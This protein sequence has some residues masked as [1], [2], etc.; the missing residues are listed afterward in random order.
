MSLFS[1]L[2]GKNT[3]EQKQA[4]LP[5]NKQEAL[6]KQEADT[7]QQ[8]QSLKTIQQDMKSNP[9][10]SLIQTAQIEAQRLEKESKPSPPS[11]KKIRQRDKLLAAKAIVPPPMNYGTGRS[12]SFSIDHSKILIAAVILTAIL[13]FLS[14]DKKVALKSLSQWFPALAS[15]FSGKENYRVIHRADPTKKSGLLDLQPA[16]EEPAESSVIYTHV[17]K[18]I[19]APP[20]SAQKLAEQ[21]SPEQKS[22]EQ[23]PAQ[24]IAPAG[25][26][27]ISIK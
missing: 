10:V 4:P 7:P 20:R 8:P 6:S 9:Y 18:V 25:G 1:R 21:K 22:A 26:S 12:S 3:P 16:P 5:L 27:V 14:F 17:D 19:P 11:A 13:M 24:K 15:Q 23:K 2:F